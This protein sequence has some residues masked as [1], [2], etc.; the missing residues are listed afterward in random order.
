MCAINVD[1]KDIQDT[2]NVYSL[3]LIC[4]QKSKPLF[5]CVS[6]FFIREVSTSYCS[7]Q[8]LYC[9]LLTEICYF[10]QLSLNSLYDQNVLMI[11]LFVLSIFRKTFYANVLPLTC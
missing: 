9:N 1:V 2:N 6:V 4:G 3:C 8:M 11:E 7:P 5:Q 10:I